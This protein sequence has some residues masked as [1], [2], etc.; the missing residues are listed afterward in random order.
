MDA[1][2]E[3]RYSNGMWRGVIKLM[4]IGIPVLLLLGLLITG[5]MRLREVSNRAQ[6]QNNLRKI[7]LFGFAEYSEHEF[8]PGDPKS[9]RTF[10]TGTIPNVNLKPEKRLSWMVTLL[11]S[12]GQDNLYGK[13]DLKRGWDD[14]VN[15]AAISEIVAAYACPSQYVA[16]SPRSPQANPYIGMAGL[17]VDAPMLLASD[18]RAGFIRYGDPTKLSILRRGLSETITILET[19]RDHGPWAAGGPPTVRGLNTDETPFIGLG[20]QFGGHPGGCNS[21]FA[22]GSVRFLSDSMSPE[23]LQRLIPLGESSGP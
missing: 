9:D 19:A 5:I 16:P 10:P 1:A 17:G 8:D 3:V 22:D 6:C 15:Q 2:G 20:L 12:L 23:V 13:F 14:E 18:P 4:L 7:G 21:A 11:P